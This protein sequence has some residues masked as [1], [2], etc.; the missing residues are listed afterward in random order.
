M[1]KKVTFKLSKIKYRGKSIGD[2]IQATIEIDNESLFVDRK[3]KKGT[4]RVYNEEIGAF[5]TSQSNFIADVKITIVE[6]DIRFND[7]A[8]VI[9]TLKLDL[10]NQKRFFNIFGQ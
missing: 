7:V 6:D 3:I 10:S 2:D 9:K 5:V 1:L 4:T 8:N